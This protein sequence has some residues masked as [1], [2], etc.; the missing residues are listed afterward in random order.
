[1][2]ISNFK[3]TSNL[4]N[5]DLSHY[6]N[7]KFLVIS[8]TPSPSNKFLQIPEHSSSTT[9]DDID[10]ISKLFQGSL[11]LNLESLTLKDI[12]LRPSDSKL[13]INSI[14]SSTLKDLSLINCHE[15]LFEDDQVI[16]RTPPNYTFLSD[17][18]FPYLE[19][20]NLKMT[21]ELNFNIPTLTFM[22][23]FKNLQR[24]NLYLQYNRAENINQNLAITLESIPN[25]KLTFLDLK[26]DLPDSLLKFKA[27]DYN[28]DALRKL[29]N[30]K[31][32][33]YLSLQINQY[34]IT[35][36]FKLVEPL[37]EL[38]CLKL[39]L[40]DSKLNKSKSPENSLINAEVLQFNSTLKSDNFYHFNN[41]ARDFKSYLPKLKW[42]QFYNNC[43]EDYIFECVDG[44]VQYREGISKVFSFIINQVLYT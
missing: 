7:L 36:L 18:S 25:N 15:V 42:V 19:T 38:K 27:F 16:R 23:R 35:N 33:T 41:L 30:F 31:K 12:H 6:P 3:T 13:L 8:K 29:S 5:V 2:N 37:K 4:S 14:N 1:M 20:L 26:L 10:C 43:I 21:N 24:L 32:L 40:D 39:N 34:Q 9:P 44:H 28:I 11:L 17:L 22:S